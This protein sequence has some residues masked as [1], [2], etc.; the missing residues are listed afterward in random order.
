[1][2]VEID[3]PGSLRFNEK[4]DATGELIRAI[5]YQL[6]PI[7][8]LHPN[9]MF[10]PCS[11]EWYLSRCDLVSSPSENAPTLDFSSLPG[12]RPLKMTSQMKVARAGPLDGFNFDGFRTKEGGEAGNTNKIFL[13]PMQA[14]PGKSSSSDPWNSSKLYDYQRETAYGF[15]GDPSSAPCYYNIYS[16]GDRTRH[17]ISYYFFYG[18]NGGLGPT[19]K[20]DGEPLGLNCG[21]G[22]HFGDWERVTVL[23]E[24]TPGS[25]S[26]KLKAVMGEQHGDEVVFRES[27]TIA[28]VEQLGRIEVYAA[29]HSHA[30]YPDVGTHR[31]GIDFTSDKGV[32]WDTRKALTSI[33]ERIRDLGKQI[34]DPFGD[35]PYWVYFNGDWG[36]RVVLDDGTIVGIFEG[37]LVG[38]PSGPA[39]KKFWEVDPGGK[40]GPS[41]PFAV[42]P[43]ASLLPGLSGFAAAPDDSGA[44]YVWAYGQGDGTVSINHISDQG[45]G[46]NETYRKTWSEGFSGVVGFPLGGA[47][48][49]WAYRTGDGTTC[50]HQI[51]A[52]G[53]GFT[54]KFLYK[55]DTGFSGFAAAVDASSNA[56]VWA[57]R[58]SDGVVCIHQINAGGAGF[59]Q[60]FLYKWD[61]GFSSFVGCAVA[62]VPTI[63]AYRAS[64]GIVCIHQINAGGVGFTQKFLYKWDTGYSGF[65]SAVDASGNAYVWA[66]RASDG[67]VCIH[68]INAGGAGFTQKFLY[69]WDTGFSG[70]TGFSVEG[71]PYIWA[72]RASNPTLCVHRIDQGGAGFTQLFIQTPSTVSSSDS[73]M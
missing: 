45:V 60:K 34:S 12:S 71:V 25:R 66:Y 32:A 70:F 58:A 47:P 7:V 51:N 14:A 69:R 54:Q 15:H 13:W 31:Y 68:Q 64:D 4:M 20:W 43:A 44:A 9:E 40:Y 61:T 8:H 30:T 35:R 55:W 24:T 39:F 19:A 50:I 41:S 23:V 11:V 67:V 59:T 48:Y 53:A 2:K 18:Y 6:A 17:R 5:A 36:P 52:G 63:W 65:A 22:A 10:F 28:P 72:Y 42:R 62:G 56:Y 73:T 3:D 49:V 21:Y 27:D 46:F 37:V 26:V 16:N 57:Y 33:Y 1:M 38:G 29:W